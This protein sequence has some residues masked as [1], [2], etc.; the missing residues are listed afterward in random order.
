MSLFY[1]SE[2]QKILE[3]LCKYV[4]AANVEKSNMKRKWI[5]IIS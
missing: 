1:I 3:L 5:T 2:E 4:D